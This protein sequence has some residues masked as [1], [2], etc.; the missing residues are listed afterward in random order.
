MAFHPPPRCG[1]MRVMMMMMMIDRIKND[2]LK[3][4]GYTIQDAQEVTWLF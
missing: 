3:T 1:V 2:E 4:L